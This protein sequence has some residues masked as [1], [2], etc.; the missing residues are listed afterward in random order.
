MRIQKALMREWEQLPLDQA[1]AAGIASFR[2][3]FS[4]GEPHRMLGEFIARRRK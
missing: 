4:G 1:I 3:S 2:K